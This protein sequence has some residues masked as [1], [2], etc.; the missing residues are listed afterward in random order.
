MATFA[1]LP[2]DTGI[3]IPIAV[4]VSSR[5]RSRSGPPNHHNRGIGLIR[6]VT[7]STWL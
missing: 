4:S 6:L 1:G 3:L 5:S 7:A 2:A